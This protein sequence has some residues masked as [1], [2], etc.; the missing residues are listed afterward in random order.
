MHVARPRE[1]SAVPTNDLNKPLGQSKRK[2]RFVLPVRFVTRGIAGSLALCVA[3]LAGWIML[4]DDPFGGEPMAIVSADL[5]PSQ[6]K[7]TAEEPAQTP[8]PDSPIAAAEKPGAKT[9]TIIDGSTGK[10]QE[11]NVNE[12]SGKPDAKPAS[13]PS[14]KNSVPEAAIDQ[15]LLESS[16][17]GT[18]PK[19]DADGT[20]P[21]E[22]YSRP[23]K[24]QSS[25]P[26]AAR[27]A[28]VMQGLGVGANGTAEALAKLPAA[29]TFAFAPYGTDVERW[30]ARARGGGHEVLLQVAMEP[31]DYPDNDPGPQ[32]LL[33]SIAPEQNIDRLHWFLSRFQGYVGVTGMMGARFTAA[34]PALGPVLREIGKRG[35]VYFDDGGSPRS[36]AA[37]ISSGIN[38]AFA[39][40]DAM[41]DAVATPAEIDKALDRLEATARDRGTAIGTASALPVS[42]ERISQWAKAAEARGIVL[43]PVSAVANRP[44]T[45]S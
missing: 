37:Q 7:K 23:V 26:D 38:V 39:K 10:R 45:S 22:M 12:P 30:V 14:T 20:R 29:I 13:K 18:I 15:R 6:A 2:K 17:H 27:I 34:E 43:V 42:I 8:K 24:P 19:I 28:I 1:P 32:T 21:S 3:V 4:V 40:S 44:K 9:V 25:L 11:I 41:L 16:R 33:T 35:L 5:R 36:V 31:F